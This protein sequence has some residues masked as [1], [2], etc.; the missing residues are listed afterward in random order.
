ML[1]K[2]SCVNGRTNCLTVFTIMYTYFHNK[3]VISEII[4]VARNLKWLRGFDWDPARKFIWD[5]TPGKIFNQSCV[6]VYCIGYLPQFVSKLYG[7]TVL[8]R[9][10]C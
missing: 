6:L 3:Y 7:S 1:K 8:S 5:V 9:K 2:R 4:G 10:I